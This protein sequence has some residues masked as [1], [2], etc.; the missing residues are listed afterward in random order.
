MNT[1][2]RGLKIGNILPVRS[3]M[4]G[5]NVNKNNN[6]VE[7]IS[8][9]ETILPTGMSLIDTS[10][11]SL[12]LFLPN[13]EFG[14]IKEIVLIK[15]TKPVI[16]KTLN[17][18]YKLDSDNAYKRLIFLDN[19]WKS[20]SKDTTCFPLSQIV[21][22]CSKNII[23]KSN[24]A[25]GSSLCFSGDGKT[26]AVGCSGD[27]VIS[28]PI[29]CVF[30]YVLDILSNQWIEQAKVVGSDTLKFMSAQGYSVALN[31]TGDILVVGGPTDNLMKGA[32]WIWKREFSNPND[33]YTKNCYWR[34][35]LKYTM[36]GYMNFGC[37]V[38]INSKGDLIAVGSDYDVGGVWIYS[39]GEPMFILPPKDELLFLS[40][41]LDIKSCGSNVILNNIGNI[42]AF[43]SKN[44]LWIYEK[45]NGI[46]TYS[47]HSIGDFNIQFG[48]SLSMNSDGTVIAVGCPIDNNNVGSAYIYTFNKEWSFTKVS[49]NGNI[50]MSKQ[51]LSVSLNGKGDMLAIGGPD[52]NNHV[53]AVW[54]F[55]NT[56]K[57]WI[58]Y[59]KYV[60]ENMI[61]S[62]SGYI[63]SGITVAL[64]SLG[65]C[66]AIGNIM[67]DN[68]GSVSMFN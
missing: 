1:V 64:D 54:L 30:I 42:L 22:L 65:S 45:K 46:F 62:N 26:L 55:V 6:N 31:N 56:N 21:K 13:T 23:G 14:T 49:G 33:K 12:I 19:G 38:S 43:T 51:G 35:T 16:L 34:N 63:S 60:C 58:E 53:G 47:Y 52:D 4:K 18:G 48:I 5:L 7:Y 66:M 67:D 3:D 11:D 2:K 24:I 59:N 61:K 15:G 25:Q 29:G 9:S 44:V 27:N 10:T 68:I 40:S 37:S 17:G 57:G 20:L 39:S 32:V 8:K 50:G 41:D 36:N 28:G